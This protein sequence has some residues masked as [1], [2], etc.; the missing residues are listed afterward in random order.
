[1]FQIEVTAEGDGL[2]LRLVCYACNKIIDEYQSFV[3]VIHA[4]LSTLSVRA[5]DH[6][7]RCHS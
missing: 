2:K 3:L 5:G 4:D 6:M 1:M 7:T